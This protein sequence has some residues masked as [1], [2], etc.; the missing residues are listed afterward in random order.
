MAR[1][2]R[3]AMLGPT[4]RAARSDLSF[5]AA[6]RYL[7]QAVLRSG[8]E[9]TMSDRRKIRVNLLIGCTAGGKGRVG[10]EIARR[11]G[12]EIVSVDS[13]KVYRRMDIGTAKPSPEARG[14]IPHHL[15]DVVE[16]SES[17]SLARYLE[18][19][20]E[21]FRDIAGRGKPILAVGGTM[22]YVQGLTTG[23]FEGPRADEAFRRGL[24]ARA[25]REGTAVLHGELARMDP[26]AADRI[27]PNDLRRIERGLEVLHVTGV[28]ISRL[29][30]QWTEPECPYDCRLVALRRA[31]DATNRRINGRVKRMI[32][33]GLVEEVRSLSAEPGGIGPQA[34]QAVGYAEL[35]HHLAGDMTLEDA[36]EQIKINSRRLGKHQRT[37]M[38]RLPNVHWVDVAEE[39]TS[40]D[41]AEEVIAAWE[42]V[43]D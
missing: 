2:V 5:G 17:F 42:R 34:A 39:D 19:A 6:R 12:G 37:W 7:E 24:R 22:L 16:P 1:S 18:Q 10:L 31:K 15:I 14:E 27:H 20:G 21:A 4:L 32:E 25:R 23:I 28:P 40:A 26:E 43:A 41:V 33:D 38:R 11:F 29:Q 8:V 35:L 3:V 13:M 30:T 36:V 9:T